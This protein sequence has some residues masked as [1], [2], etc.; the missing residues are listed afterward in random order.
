MKKLMSERILGATLL[1]TM[2]VVWIPSVDAAGPSANRIKQG[3]GV[4][5]ELSDS[6]LNQAQKTAVDTPVQTKRQRPASPS[7][8]LD[9]VWRDASGK[10]LLIKKIHS[11]LYLSGSSDLAAWQAQCVGSASR[12][13]C[14]GKGISRT[15]GEF[16][17]ESELHTQKGRLLIDWQHH[18][19]NGSNDSGSDQ[20]TPF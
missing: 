17:Y 15:A 19:S 18:Y 16:Q 4:L 5:S 8:N 12:A 7:G 3:P 13:R 2:L 14:M 9:G 20:A 1:L 10:V 6:E 11:T